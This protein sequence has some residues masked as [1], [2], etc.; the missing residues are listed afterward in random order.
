MPE[1]AIRA[2]AIYCGSRTGHGESHRALAATVGRLLALAGV[3]VVYGG[4][5][6]GLMGVV[7]RAALAH[8]GRVVGIIPHFLDAL[9]VGQ[10]G[11]TEMIRVE[12]MHERK[13]LML[14]KA[15][16]VLAL[17]G[18]IG[19]LDELLEVITWRELKLHDKPIY[20]LGPD[21]YWAPFV[22]LLQHIDANGFAP[23]DLFDLFAVLPDCASLAAALNLP[24]G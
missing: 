8:G 18:S 19:T 3:S 12:T 23:A 11:L 6:V 9:E 24:S 10:E 16:A 20:L 5:S 2:V 22:A 17:P 1:P 15:D 13:W 14:Q 7:A 4:G 21:D